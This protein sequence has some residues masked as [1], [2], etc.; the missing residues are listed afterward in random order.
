[1]LCRARSLACLLQ[2]WGNLMGQFD[3]SWRES[4]KIRGVVLPILTATPRRWRVLWEKLVLM[5]V[6]AEQMSDR[7]ARAKYQEFGDFD[8]AADKSLRIGNRAE[9]ISAQERRIQDLEMGRI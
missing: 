3:L 4:A 8:L 6:Q 9:I 2:E 7:H 1:M 5:S